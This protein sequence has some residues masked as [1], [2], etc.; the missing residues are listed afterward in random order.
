MDN[1]YSPPALKAEQM[2]A[3]QAIL[4]PS[5]R[6]AQML[7]AWRGADQRYW[8]GSLT[9]CWLTAN[10]EPYGHCI[11]SWNE[12]T[13]TLNLVPALWPAKAIAKAE[14]IHCSDTS[15]EDRVEQWRPILQ[16]ISQDNISINHWSLSCGGRS[17]LGLDIRLLKV[18]KDDVYKYSIPYP[19]HG[20]VCI[21]LN[22]ADN[23]LERVIVAKTAMGPFNGEAG[24]PEEWDRRAKSIARDVRKFLKQGDA[25][26]VLEPRLM[27]IE[28]HNYGMEM[29]AGVIV[30]E[31][32]HQAQSQLYSEL[33]DATGPKTWTDSSHRCP[34]WSRACEDVLQA[35]EMPWFM[36]VWHRSTG[37]Q[38]NPWVPDSSDWMAWR[39]VE[40]DSTFD[41]RKLISMR[42]ARSFMGNTKLT[43]DELIESLGFPV[44]T[45]K[46]KPID[47]TL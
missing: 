10:I 30:H 31:A 11:G 28:E 37:N 27:A 34:S 35:E 7:E 1:T 32:C 40:P 33:D 5:T 25:L 42:G 24:V 46:G 44:L 14:F 21:D 15:S 36:P 3:L 12:A 45:P 18:H 16:R 47:W 17:A 39:K 38:W 4:P 6:V 22:W 29:V 43:L 13:R 41:G 19:E 26:P 2:E 9:P 20:A 23:T 8:N